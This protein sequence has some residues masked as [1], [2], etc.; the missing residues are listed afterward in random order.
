[1]PTTAPAPALEA[2]KPPAV[3][4]REQPWLPL[5]L[6][7]LII[8]VGAWVRLSGH[9]T[10]PFSEDE[11][12]HVFAARSLSATGE[13]A[14]PSGWHYLRGI[15]FTRMV[16][17]F[18]ARVADPELA[19]RLPSALAGSA[20]LLIMAAVAWRLAGPWPA[21]WA[22]LLLALFPLAVIESRR[23]RFYTWQ[24]VWLLVSL[25]A[26][27]RALTG[28]WRA[29][30]PRTDGTAPDHRRLYQ[31]PDLPPVAAAWLWLL[32]AL[33]GFG[34]AYRAQQTTLSVAAGFGVALFATAGAHLRGRRGAAWRTSVPLQASTLAVAG[35][36]AALLL[37]PALFTVLRETALFPGPGIEG[38]G[39]RRNYYWAISGPFPLLASLVPLVFLAGFLLRPR[40]T[41][42]L[43][44]W[45]AVPFLLH[46]LV[47]PWRAARFIFGAYPA[48]FIA[49]GIA[50][51]A[52]CGLL[53]RML[54]TRLAAQ[55]PGSVPPRAAR[56]MA[57]GAVAA[58]A[59]GAVLTSPGTL[60][61]LRRPV[62]APWLGW[63]QAAALLE[64]RD[65][66]RRF[67][68]GASF[69]MQALE[70]MGRVDFT[71][72]ANYR[73]TP[74]EIQP[75]ASGHPPGVGTAEV[76]RYTGRVLLLDPAAIRRAYPATDTVAII[77][78]DPGDNEWIT[79]L[80]R[81]ALAADGRELCAGRCPGLRLYLWAPHVQHG[82]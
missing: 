17:F 66:L 70:Y 5:L 12:N 31:V 41:A 78:Y 11:L 60:Q 10:Q 29:A 53:Y 49:A 67:P 7:I 72:G 39:V 34:I 40:L 71:V 9:G 76:D 46:T 58:V 37:E 79:P 27:W 13:P 36:L 65:P 16:Q 75:L 59:M 57:V 80:L 77:V 15:D 56:I 14:L 82:P 73:F 19:A 43:F 21:V 4:R 74:L 69:P 44:A 20:G 50:A 28:S 64:E 18:Q 30:L 23:S 6:L 3:T 52:A 2:P 68:L 32:V 22:T 62:G 55:G 24:M 25:F 33:V 51:A 81:D 35:A 26:G 61:S 38:G 63:H 54:L 48:L 47:F 1:M 45:F 42:Y 8:S